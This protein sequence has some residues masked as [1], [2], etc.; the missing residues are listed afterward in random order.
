M[1]ERWPSVTEADMQRDSQ[2]SSCRDGRLQCRPQDY[3]ISDGTS[4]SFKARIQQSNKL[5]SNIPRRHKHRFCMNNKPLSDRILREVLLSGPLPWVSSQALLGADSHTALQ[6][7]VCWIQGLLIALVH[8]QILVSHACNRP[9]GP[10]PSKPNPLSLVQSRERHTNPKGDTGLRALVQE[11]LFAPKHPKATP[12]P[13]IYNI[14][15]CATSIERGACHFITLQE[16]F[17]SAHFGPSNLLFNKHPTCP[18]S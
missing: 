2:A 8:Q 13:C 10:C 11:P 18:Y 5:L 17:H 14:A 1:Q 7:L 9:S 4:V 15:P 3:Y 6:S 12:G 16:S